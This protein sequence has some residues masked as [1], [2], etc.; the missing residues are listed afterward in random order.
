M[1]MAK[2]MPRMF[3]YVDFNIE[4]AQAAFMMAVVVLTSHV[5]TN[6]R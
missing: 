2:H 6:L 3:R 4:D 1:V 5:T